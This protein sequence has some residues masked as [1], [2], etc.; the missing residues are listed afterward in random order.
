MTL[1]EP[2]PQSLKRLLR[3]EDEKRIR[4]L[5]KPVQVVPL[6][7]FNTLQS[8]DLLF[9]DSSHVMK[10]GSDVQ[11]LLFE[12]LPRLPAGVFVHFH[13]VLRNFEYPR[14]WLESGIYWNEDYVLRAFLAYNNAW[15]IYFFN[16][17]VGF[18]FQQF[19]AENMP[20]C[21]KN[22]GGSLYL[23]RTETT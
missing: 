3:P 18:V 9:L 6:S 23:R 17:H 13:D 20:L 5:D 10:C 11:F 7:I 2:Y 4:V 8:G 14:Y 16:D 21:R 15:D 1:I 22:P 19:I 12:V